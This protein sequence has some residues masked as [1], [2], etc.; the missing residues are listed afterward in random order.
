MTPL[1]QSIQKWQ[2]IVDGVGHDAGAENCALCG[3]YLQNSCNGCPIHTQ[4]G[5]GCGK[6]P[7]GSWYA[8]HTHVLGEVEEKRV[9]DASS[10][11]LAKI[12]LEFL[13][14]LENQNDI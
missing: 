4:Y 14:S 12:E 1:Q 11:K 2:D 13:Q 3:V 9:F 10:L 6:T 7:Y 8:Y 5:V